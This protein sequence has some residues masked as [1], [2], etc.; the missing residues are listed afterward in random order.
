[1]SQTRSKLNRMN[2]TLAGC[3]LAAACLAPAGATSNP[4]AGMVAINY[5][6]CDSDYAGWGA[7]L[8]K[9]GGIPLPGVDWKNPMKPTGKTDF[10]V[11]WHVKADEFGAKTNVNYILHKGDS[12]DQGGKDMSFDGAASKEVWVNSGDRKIYT[13]LDDAK[14][15]RAESPCK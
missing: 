1:M 13:S 15:A 8:W 4:A 9:E 11:Y 14:K 2:R 5:N 12:K 6:R 3:A 7:H 10:G